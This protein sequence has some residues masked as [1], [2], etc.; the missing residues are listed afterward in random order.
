[1][2]GGGGRC[3]CVGGG[4]CGGGRACPDPGWC[5]RGPSWRL[6]SRR[7]RIGWRRQRSRARRVGSRIGRPSR[8]RDDGRRQPPKPIG[9]RARR[10]LQ[11]LRREVLHQTPR[12]TQETVLV[13][14]HRHPHRDAIKPSRNQLG[15]HRRRDRHRHVRTPAR[16]PVPPA[17]NAAPNTR[18]ATVTERPGSGSPAHWPLRNRRGSDRNPAPRRHERQAATSTPAF[19]RRQLDPFL[20][21]G[22]GANLVFAQRGANT[23]FAPT[24]PWPGLPR[25]CPRGF[26][27]P[28]AGS[29][30]SCRLRAP[31]LR[32]ALRANNSRSRIRSLASDA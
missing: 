19:L 30:A 10:E 8:R 3:L 7:P 21:D 27:A 20:L 32:S 17:P 22:V 26:R 15:R 28:V 5:R 24:R 31:G 16:P 6:G 2:S 11:P 4:R 18:A 1:M 9:H 14:Q 12:R 13:Q 25:G 29:G 23:R